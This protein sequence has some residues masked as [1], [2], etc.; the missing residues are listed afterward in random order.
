METLTDI[1]RTI[2]IGFFAGIG[3][4]GAVVIWS[5]VMP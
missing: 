3:F 1:I 5:L 2:A 4:G